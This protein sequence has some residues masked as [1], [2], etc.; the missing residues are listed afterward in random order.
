M[1]ILLIFV[2]FFILLC[3]QAARFRPPATPTPAADAIPV[4]GEQAVSHLQAAIRCR[5]V[6]EESLRVEAEFEK[7]RSLLPEFY[8]RLFSTG[9]VERIDR[10][11]LLIRIP[12]RESRSPAVFLGHYD[13]VPAEV[14]GWEKPPFAAVLEDGVL[15]GRGA[16]DM[17]NQLISMLEAAELLLTQGFTPKNDIYFALS[18]EEEVMGPSARS[19]MERFRERGIT[20]AFVLDEGGDIMDGFFPGTDVPCAMVGIGEKGAA[21][22]RFRVTGPGGHASTPPKNSPLHR[23][24]RAMTRIEKHPFPRKPGRALEEMVNTMG[25]YCKFST[26]LL[27]SNRKLLWPFYLRWLRKQGGMIDAA[28]RT[29]FALTKAQGSQ[30]G[31]VIP[32]EAEMFANLR[33]MYGWT[34]ESVVAHLHRIIRDDAVEIIPEKGTDPAPDSELGEPFDR[35]KAAINATWPQAV[36]S[37]YLMVA[38]T[39]ARHWREICP[40]VYRFSAKYVTGEEKSTVHGNNERIRTINTENAV[41]FF[42]RLMREC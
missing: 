42:F 13:V 6:S 27:L 35:L 1:I 11:G 10:T 19:I 38:C 2:L 31:N 21:N 33:L 24:C 32:S 7:F 14:T 18:G 39:D 36:V 30:A 25:P 3:V 8:P 40:H 41:K 28:A 26:R 5:T 12:G 16:L 15:W 22:L 23:L 17:K 29:T 4:D 34:Q 37:P 9:N 20:P